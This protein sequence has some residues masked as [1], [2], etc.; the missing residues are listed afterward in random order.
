M[1]N[2]KLNPVCE[3][4]RPYLAEDQAIPD[5][6]RRITSLLKLLQLDFQ[7]SSQ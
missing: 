5:G 2:V 6:V 7:S 3:V 4:D 1:E